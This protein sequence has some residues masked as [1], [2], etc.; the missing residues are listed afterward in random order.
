M[1]WSRKV[2]RLRRS[3]GLRALALALWREDLWWW[4]LCAVALEVV[5]ALALWAGGECPWVMLALG[6]CMWA[7]WW[8]LLLLLVALPGRWCLSSGA[9]G[10]VWW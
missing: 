7:W 4:G 10:D 2:R 3:E 1:P 5:F 6:L 8:L 9:P